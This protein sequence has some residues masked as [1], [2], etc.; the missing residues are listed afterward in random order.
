VLRYTFQWGHHASVE[1]RL[2][3]PHGMLGSFYDDLV[4]A[5]HLTRTATTSSS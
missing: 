1:D 3:V 5:G 2:G 4:A